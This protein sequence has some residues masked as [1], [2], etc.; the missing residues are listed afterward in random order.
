MAQVS[1]SFSGLFP[2][3]RG[4]RRRCLLVLVLLGLVCAL[5]VARASSSSEGAKQQVQELSDDYVSE[6]GE[7]GS[8]PVSSLVTRNSRAAAKSSG[9]LAK[10]AALL[11]SA[12]VAVAVAFL[13]K[14]DIL[15]LFSSEGDDIKTIGSPKSPEKKQAAKRNKKNMVVISAALV[16]AAVAAGSLYYQLSGAQQAVEDI[17]PSVSKDE[18]TSRLF[19]QILPHVG[20][21][22]GVPESIKQYLPSNLLDYVPTDPAT[23]ALATLAA[24]AVGLHVMLIGPV[25][26]AF[27]LN[28]LTRLLREYEEAAPA[29]PEGEEPAKVPPAVKSAQEEKAA[30]E[31]KRARKWKLGKALDL[32][33]GLY[34]GLYDRVSRIKPAKKD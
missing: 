14:D 33:A 31:A 17:L 2:V 5:S 13:K 10:K 8:Q 7:E 16:A 15:A 34:V 18:E 9:S 4:G 21:A 27:K 1:Q 30:I 29:V 32:V 23:Q 12:V 11:V 22:P 6:E 26:D 25:R 24:A 3:V 20:D 28:K 19:E